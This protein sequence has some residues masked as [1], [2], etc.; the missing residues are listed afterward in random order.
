MSLD[1]VIHEIKNEIQRLTQVLGLLSGVGGK[2]KRA[3]RK[4]SAEGRKRISQAQKKRWA[5]FK[6]GKK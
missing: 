1:G 4:I 2:V 3:R 6:A 5:K